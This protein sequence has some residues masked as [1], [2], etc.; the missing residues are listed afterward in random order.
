MLEETG[1]DVK[2]H[3]FTGRCWGECL[4]SKGELCGECR[5]EQEQA[6]ALEKQVECFDFGGLGP[7]PPCPTLCRQEATDFT[8]ARERKRADFSGQ[9]LGQQTQLSVSRVNRRLPTPVADHCSLM[10]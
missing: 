1:G 2:R 5:R 6:A 4:G 8:A 9:G 3:S 10:M 7:P